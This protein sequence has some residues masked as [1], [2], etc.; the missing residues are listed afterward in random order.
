MF[1]QDETTLIFFTGLSRELFRCMCNF[2]CHIRKQSFLVQDITVIENKLCFSLL[3]SIQFFGPHFSYSFSLNSTIRVNFFTQFVFFPVFLNS[4]VLQ[5]KS[6]PP[7]LDTGCLQ[8]QINYGR[9]N[10]LLKM[11][12]FEEGAGE[13][14][15]AAILLNQYGLFLSQSFSCCFQ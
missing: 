13:T 4:P 5:N 8:D 10:S 11:P 15:A 3:I 1:G 7:D 2:Y 14:R 9:T 6:Y 12:T